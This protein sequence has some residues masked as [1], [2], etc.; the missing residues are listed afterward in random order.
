M[1][2][3]IEGQKRMNAVSSH[4]GREE[5]QKRPKLVP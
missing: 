5:K 3:G 4:G 1:V 2:G